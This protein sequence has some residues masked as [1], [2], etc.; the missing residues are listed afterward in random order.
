MRKSLFI[1]ICTLSSILLAGLV[2]AQED[3]VDRLNV[4]FSD[5]TQP[6]FVELDL[7]NGA[8]TVTG[9]N[10]DEVLIEARTRLKAIEQKK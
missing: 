2:P 10:G 8:I 1:L 7:V 4:K 6:G 5:P 9:Y 3:L